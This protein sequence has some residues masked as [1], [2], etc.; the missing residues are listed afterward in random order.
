MLQLAGFSWDISVQ[1]LVVKWRIYRIAKAS[2]GWFLFRWSSVLKK[3]FGLFFRNAKGFICL[4]YGNSHGIHLFLFESRHE[5]HPARYIFF[6]AE[7]DCGVQVALYL[8]SALHKLQL[9][10][11]SE[12]HHFREENDVRKWC[13]MC[14]FLCGNF[15]IMLAEEFHPWA[16]S[17][18]ASVC[19]WNGHI[20]SSESW[21]FLRRFDIDF[22]WG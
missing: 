12:R 2:R 18:D 10:L 11:I 4:H 19:P 3:T 13:Y 21:V 5:H 16:L 7:W 20:L 1:N 14:C 8:V 6:R 22:R 9:V 15:M 17:N